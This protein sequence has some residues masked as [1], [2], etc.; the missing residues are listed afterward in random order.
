MTKHVTALFHN[1]NEA[2]RA[3][4]ALIRAG[5]KR[6]EISLFAGDAV[7]ANHF[8]LADKS[9]APEGATT[10]GIIGGALGLIAGAAVTATTA[11]VG[12]L[13]TGPILVGLAGLGAGGVVGGLVGGLV[14]LGIPEREA[15][16]YDEQ[17]R[18]R[19][20]ILIGVTTD[21]LDTRKIEAILDEFETASVDIRA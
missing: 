19:D 11:G 20:A 10:G 12:I 17:I 14:G 2:A 7:L 8:G 4:E 6:E 9:K 3:V 16:Y 1:P 21:D 15:K 13:A 5:V 18:E